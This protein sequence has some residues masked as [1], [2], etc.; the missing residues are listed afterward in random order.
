MGGR[1][2]RRDRGARRS[3]RHRSVEKVSTGPV[4]SRRVLDE[5]RELGHHGGDPLAGDIGHQVEPVRADVADGPES[6]AAFRLEAPVPVG[7]EQQPVLE[8]A[9]GDEPDVPSPPSAMS[10]A[11]G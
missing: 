5:G 9:A 11:P 6:A 2:L 7:L 1:V 8:V 4:G 3:R 10:R